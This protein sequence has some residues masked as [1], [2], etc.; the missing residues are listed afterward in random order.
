LFGFGFG[1]GWLVGFVFEN[2]VSLCSSG[3]P[4]THSVDQ[5]GLEL[6]DPL[7]SAS[8]VLELKAWHIE[9]ILKDFLNDFSTLLGFVLRVL[10]LQTKPTHPESIC[11]HGPT[12][13]LS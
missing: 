8:G 2:R 6:R 13:F 12:I 3:C 5:T 9:D 4:G 7:A 1:F 11:I 10:P